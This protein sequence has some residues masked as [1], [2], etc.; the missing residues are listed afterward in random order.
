[1]TEN[2]HECQPFID[3]VVSVL[4]CDQLPSVNLSLDCRCAS[5]LTTLGAQSLSLSRELGC[6]NESSSAVFSEE[7]P[8]L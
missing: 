2:T 7:E 8:E 5:D 4:V 1:M 3:R 6:W